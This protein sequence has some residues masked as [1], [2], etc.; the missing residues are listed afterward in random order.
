MNMQ[1][2]P[3]L[4]E[5]LPILCWRKGA[6]H[7]STDRRLLDA[8]FVRRCLR[9]DIDPAALDSRNLCFGLYRKRHQ[10][11]FA[12][13]VT[14]YATRASVSL[15]FI[16]AEYRGVGLGSWLMRCCLAHPAMRGLRVSSPAGL[17]PWR[18]C[19]AQQ[20]ARSIH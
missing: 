3:I 16:S 5:H 1:S 4:T 11:G 12:R 14:D 17:S 15:L 8:D 7:I 13:V 10:L 9:Q 20:T 2:L 6:F 18:A 19:G